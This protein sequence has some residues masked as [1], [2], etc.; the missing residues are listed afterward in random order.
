LSPVVE[1]NY[2]DLVCM[3]QLLTALGLLLS[4]QH[5]NVAN[6]NDE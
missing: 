3:N 2:S 1:Q 6:F 5:E 4:K